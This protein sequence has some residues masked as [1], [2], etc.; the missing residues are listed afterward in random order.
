MMAST[1]RKVTPKKKIMLEDDGIFSEALQVIIH[2]APSEAHMERASEAVGLDRNLL[3]ICST[4]GELLAFILTVK[5]AGG[6]PVAMKEVLDRFS[7][8]AGRAAAVDVNIAAGAAAPMA[9]KNSEEQAAASSFM[10][11][12]RIV[13]QS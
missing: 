5:A 11:S 8:K 3:P 4:V 1:I 2:D 6:E 10:D 7:P 9:S 12:L 13:P